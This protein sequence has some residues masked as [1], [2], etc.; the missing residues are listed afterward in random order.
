MLWHRCETAASCDRVKSA[1]CCRERRRRVRASLWGVPRRPT[2][3]S[4]LSGLEGRAAELPGEQPGGVDRRVAFRHADLGVDAVLQL[5]VAEGLPHSARA[6][7][8]VTVLQRRRGG[9]FK[10][11]ALEGNGLLHPGILEKCSDGPR[12]TRR[13]RSRKLGSP[14]SPSA[15]E[16]LRSPTGGGKRS[17]RPFAGVLE[18]LRKG[19]EKEQSS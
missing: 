10:F 6:V 15:R 18:S 8:G 7:A 19:E 16:R 14:G 13:R 12:S 3:R 9:A 11:G 2:S 5:L 4:H 1:Y 17:Q